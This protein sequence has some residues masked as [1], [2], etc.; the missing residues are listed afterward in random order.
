MSSTRNGRG[1]S[2]RPCRERHVKC[3]RGTPSCSN[4]TRS[5]YLLNCVYESPQFK[6]RTRI[7][8]SRASADDTNRRSRARASSSAGSPSEASP[9]PVESSPPQQTGHGAPRGAVTHESVWSSPAE[10]QSNLQ[11]Q[12]ALPDPGSSGPAND[13]IDNPTKDITAPGNLP[14]GIPYSTSLID[15]AAQSVSV[16]AEADIFSF[17]LHTV[18]PWVSLSS[19]NCALVKLISAARH[20]LAISIIR[21]SRSPHGSQRAGAAVCLSSVWLPRHV[22]PPSHSFGGQG[23]SP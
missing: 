7:L 9:A 14:A 3:D 1:A 4:C 11:L 5:R 2:C 17:Y 23:D 10:Q 13:F 18:G 22:P 15:A 12:P 21:P 16:R 19:T 8:A 20:C 6:F